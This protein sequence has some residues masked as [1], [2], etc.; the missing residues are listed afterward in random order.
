MSKNLNSKRPKIIRRSI[1][2]TT[3][4]NHLTILTQYIM[5]HRKKYFLK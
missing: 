1:V 2:E 4:G 5:T 3:Y